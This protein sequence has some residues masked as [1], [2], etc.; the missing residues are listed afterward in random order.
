MLCV[1]P[2]RI[3][4]ETSAENDEHEVNEKPKRRLTVVTPLSQK[5]VTDEYKTIKQTKFRN[6]QQKGIVLRV[7][8]LLFFIVFLRALNTTDINIAC[9]MWF[10]VLFLS[11]C[12]GRHSEAQQYSRRLV[13]LFSKSRFAFLSKTCNLNSHDIRLNEQMERIS[14]SSDLS[15][16]RL[17]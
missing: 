7:T 4:D 17:R 8:L 12:F 10:F 16:K 13:H 9:D 5:Q 2:Q 1:G 14:S 3:Y 11:F 6:I 15:V